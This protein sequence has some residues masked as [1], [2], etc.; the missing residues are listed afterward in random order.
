M[1]GAR[2]FV[3]V[4]DV[5]GNRVLFEVVIQDPSRISRVRSGAQGTADDARNRID[6]DEV[7]LGCRYGRRYGFDDVEPAFDLDLKTG[8]FEDLALRSIV[9]RLAPF[10]SPAGNHPGSDQRGLAAANQKKAVFRVEDECANADDGTPFTQAVGGL[11]IA[12]EEAPGA[13]SG[14]GAFM[15]R[16]ID[17]TRY[18]KM[19]DSV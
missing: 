19:P 18:M 1:N 6:D 15:D 10:Q 13:T 8:F 4:R 17:G 7:K 2:R 12:T 14:T 16:R 11:S 3:E 9:D 5:S